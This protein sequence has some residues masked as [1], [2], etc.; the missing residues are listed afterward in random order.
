MTGL[1]RDE[2][3]F[4]GLDRDRRAGD[5]AISRRIGIVEGA[6]RALVAGCDLLCI[7]GGLA[8]ED[9]VDRRS[10]MRSPPRSP[11]SPR[12]S[13]LAE[14]A[15]RVDAAGELAGRAAGAGGG[16]RPRGGPRAPPASAARRRRRACR[17][18]CG[19][20]PAPRSR[21]MAA[22]VIPWGVARDRSPSAEPECHPRIRATATG[23]S[24]SLRRAQGARR[25]ASCSPCATSTVTHGSRRRPMP[26]C[27]RRAPTP[28]WSR[29]GCPPAG[30]RARRAYIA[31]SGAARVCG[32][33]AAEVMR[34]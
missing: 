22:G 32:V 33:A 29:W 4:D 13:R 11:R 21:S 16:A 25:A 14:A 30:R 23:R 27:S 9:I 19:G 17:R 3:G 31:T 2:L 24:T 5:G 12:R 7:G 10:A 8:D 20:G 1:L 28:S 26:C 6:V 18:R 15:G 34:P